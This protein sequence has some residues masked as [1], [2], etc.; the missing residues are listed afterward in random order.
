MLTK[1]PLSA[2]IKHRL[3]SRLGISQGLYPAGKIWLNEL[4]TF[5]QCCKASSIQAKLLSDQEHMTCVV[6][7]VDVYLAAPRCESMIQ[8]TLRAS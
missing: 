2:E 7:V 3:A 6:V 4:V 5:E 8:Y 1:C